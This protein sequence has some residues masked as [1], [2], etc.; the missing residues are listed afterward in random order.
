MG[1]KAK[2]SD[3]SATQINWQIPRPQVAVFIQW[4]K[5]N[6]LPKNRVFS[7]MA[8][9]VMAATTLEERERLLQAADPSWNDRGTIE[10]PLVASDAAKKALATV[11]GVPV[12]S[13]GPAQPDR[14]KAPKRR[15][16]G[17]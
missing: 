2:K 11:L 4:L 7:A 6:N 10:P 14:G 15:S 9:I 12:E 3:E 1:R 13:L 8:N 17:R 16:A 5:A